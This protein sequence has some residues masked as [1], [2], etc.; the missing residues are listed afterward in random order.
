MEADMPTLDGNLITVEQ[1][2]RI[3]GRSVA[4]VKDWI[5]QGVIPG[6]RLPGT[7]VTWVNVRDIRDLVVSVGK[8]AP[9][10]DR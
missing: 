5:K 9:H 2:A 4:T 3:T 1:L 8:G 6:Y 10:E 7:S